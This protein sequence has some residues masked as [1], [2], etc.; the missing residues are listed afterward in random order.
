[1]R[2]RM[3]GFVACAAFLFACGSS[4]DDAGNGDDAANDSPSGDTISFDEGLRD[5][6]LPTDAPA[7]D[8]PSDVV[9]DAGPDPTDRSKCTVDPDKLGVTHRTA[10]ASTGGGSMKYVGFAPPGYAPK[11]PLSLVV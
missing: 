5:S 2:L 8:A 9:V 4:S 6:G 3:F 1:M 10:P 11:T 7:T